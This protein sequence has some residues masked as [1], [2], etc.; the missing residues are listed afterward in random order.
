MKNLLT[1]NH[2]DVLYK[3]DPELFDIFIILT[4][5]GNNPLDTLSYKY[6]S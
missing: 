3:F 4:G 2:V 6:N 5:T 1:N